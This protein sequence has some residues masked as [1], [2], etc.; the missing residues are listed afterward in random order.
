[1]VETEIS[2]DPTRSSG[3]GISFLR[4]LVIV[5]QP[6]NPKSKGHNPGQDST[7]QLTVY[8]RVKLRVISSQ[9]CLHL[10]VWRHPSY[11]L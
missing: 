1:V 7:L 4:A 8:R 2:S 11:P 6:D 3:A 5:F 10:E 9:H